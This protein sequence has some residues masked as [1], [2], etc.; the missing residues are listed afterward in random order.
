MRFPPF[1]LAVGALRSITGVLLAELAVVSDTSAILTIWFGT[2]L[3][4]GVKP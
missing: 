1:A 4:I 3:L 2:N